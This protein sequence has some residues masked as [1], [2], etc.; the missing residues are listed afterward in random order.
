MSPAKH[1]DQQPS[2]SDFWYEDKDRTTKL[3]LEVSGA[4]VLVFKC[5]PDR[6]DNQIQFDGVSLVLKDDIYFDN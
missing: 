5:S 1:P 4:G 6:I 3:F 2:T